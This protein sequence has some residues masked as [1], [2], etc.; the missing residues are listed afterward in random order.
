VVKG[1]HPTIPAT[2]FFRQHSD[3]KKRR[4]GL[5]LA[6]SSGLVTRTST[7]PG[8]LMGH[9]VYGGVNAH[10]PAESGLGVLYFDHGGTT[11]F[12]RA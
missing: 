8:W 10:E 9:A 4:S 1:N 2:H 7:S 11:P 12:E 5:S 6:Y 3:Y